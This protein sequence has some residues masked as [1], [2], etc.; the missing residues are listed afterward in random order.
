[1]PIPIALVGSGIFITTQHLPAVLT[2]PLLEFKAIYS[3]TLSSAQKLA[4]SES[5]KG[6]KLDL[7]SEDAGDGKGYED[8]LKREDIKAVIIA[9]PIPSQPSFIQSALAANK[10]V[11]AE[12]PLTPTHTTGH[13]LLTS[14]LPSLP[15]SSRPTLSIAENYRHTPILIHAATAISKLGPIQRFKIEM[16]TYM[17]PSNRYVGT[18]WR[19]DPEFQGGFL[20]DGGIH[21]VAALRLL[22]AGG[23]WMGNPGE[24]DGIK[25]VA[26]FTRL[27]SEHLAPLDTLDV[28]VELKSGATGTFGLSFGVKGK[29]RSEYVVVCEKGTVV[30]ANDEVVVTNGEGEEVE[31]T[32]VGYS[33]GVKEEVKTWAEGLEGGYS[34]AALSPYEA[35][36]DLEVLEAMLRSGER[37][38][39]VVELGDGN[40]LTQG[41][42]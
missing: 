9:L 22:L 5:L 36:R 10:H 11:L 21:F 28:I 35:L 25:K 34:D 29:R 31:R 14:F 15:S 24:G 39:A 40:T 3:R 16:S 33:S 30:V 18:A 37:G 20:L 32:P 26:A 12:K 1:M 7:Y 13:T 8:L 42:A 6:K 4:E 27:I 38:G 2:T 17:P 23:S 19:K 41:V